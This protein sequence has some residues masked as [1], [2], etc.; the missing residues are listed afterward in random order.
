MVYLESRRFLPHSSSLRRDTTNFPLKSKEDRPKPSSRTFEEVKNDHK[1]YDNAKT[2][3]V[4]CTLIIDNIYFTYFYIIHADRR[5]VQ[6]LRQL[7]A[8][9]VCLYGT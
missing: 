2:K 1:A 4:N 5:Q 7:V 6:S 3:S 9:K 8:R